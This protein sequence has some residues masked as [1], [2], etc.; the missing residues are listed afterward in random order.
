MENN[1]HFLSVDPVVSKYVANKPEITYRRSRSIGDSLV[2]S[3]YAPAAPP[4]G[5]T[6]GK[7]TFKC[8][9]CDQCPWI[10]EG[11]GCPLP[12]GGYYKSKTYADCSTTGIVY[13]AMCL[14]GAFYIGKTKSPFAKRIQDH[15]YYLDAGL[16]YTPICKH[17]GL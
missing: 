10:R 16:L 1:W 7:G 4:T 11:T 13:L 3:H 17:I 2:H 6:G 12:R 15:L 8:G 14:C 5:V 9:N